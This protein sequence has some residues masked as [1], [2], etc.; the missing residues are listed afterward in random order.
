[1][2]HFFSR[3]DLEVIHEASVFDDS[4]GHLRYFINDEGKTEKSLR[5][6]YCLAVN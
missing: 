5:R 1:M 6:E 4:V 3:P 2:Y